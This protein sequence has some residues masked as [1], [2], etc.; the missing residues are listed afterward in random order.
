MGADLLSKHHNPYLQEE[1]DSTDTEKTHLM[2]LWLMFLFVLNMIYSNTL[3]PIGERVPTAKLMTEARRLKKKF[4]R[5]YKKWANDKKKSKYDETHSFING[6]MM[7]SEDEGETEAS[8][9]NEGNRY[10]KMSP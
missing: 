6:R 1:M 5:Q 9:G 4:R 2:N 7:S 10:M 3:Q 8:S